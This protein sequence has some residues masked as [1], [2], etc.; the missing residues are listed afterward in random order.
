MLCSVVLRVAGV[1]V[2]AMA[3][4]GLVERWADHVGIGREW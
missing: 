1:V 3:V 2:L 4:E